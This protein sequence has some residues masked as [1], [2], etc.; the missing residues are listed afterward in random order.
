LLRRKL[1]WGKGEFKFRQRN[2]SSF[3]SHKNYFGNF[4]RRKIGFTA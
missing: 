4:R 2:L 3:E 1:L